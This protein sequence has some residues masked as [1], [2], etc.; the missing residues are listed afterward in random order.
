MCRRHRRAGCRG[1]TTS[2][3]VSASGIDLPLGD[4]PQG[5]SA[6]LKLKRPRGQRVL[7][8]RSGVRAGGRLFAGLSKMASPKN[9]TRSNGAMIPLSIELPLSPRRVR[10][11]LILFVLQ[12]QS[13]TPETSVLSGP[14]PAYFSSFRPSCTFTFG[15]AVDRCVSLFLNCA[16]TTLA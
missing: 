5:R 15:V 7:D 12:I 11:V 13:A 10:Q 8:G 9:G 16:R 1:G 2:G 14:P 6:I 3:D 4:A